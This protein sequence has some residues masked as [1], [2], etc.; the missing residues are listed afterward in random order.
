MGTTINCPEIR[1][2]TSLTPQDRAE[3]RDA[4]VRAFDRQFADWAEIAK[5][6]IDVERDKDYLRLG[7]K[8]WHE[9]LLDAAPMS[10][11][12]IYIV[13]GRYKELAPDISHEE[14]SKMPLGSAKV[15]ASVS[16]SVRQNPKLQSVAIKK[17]KELREFIRDNH[18][19][20]HIEGI[21]EKRLKFTTSQW[22][23]V[24]AVYEAYL[25]TDE[26]ASLETFI[27]WLCSEQ[28]V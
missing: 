4:Y 5:A 10:R 28:D 2:E 1:T 17:P 3:A 8:T 9:W 13:V 7:F 19:D 12:Y 15:L 16:S 22:E 14:L 24:E 20:Q 23:R 27:E 18:P 11:S 26:G 25:L 21:V 6:C